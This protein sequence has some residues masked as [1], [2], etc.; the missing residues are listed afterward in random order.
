MESFHDQWLS[1]RRGGGG[2]NDPIARPLSVMLMI[3][4]PL[5]ALAIQQN[6]MCAAMITGIIFGSCDLDLDPNTALSGEVN[7]AFI[8]LGMALVLFFAGLADAEFEVMRNYVMPC[9]KVGFQRLVVITGLFA[10]IGF[11]IGLC[12]GASSTAVFG[13]ACSL[14]SKKVILKFLEGG[15]QRLCTAVCC[16][17]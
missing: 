13:I 4:L 9:L 16:R 11:A 17:E 3:M 5:V 12:D 15:R 2:G 8:E 6:S 10:G 14:S 1:L 7:Y